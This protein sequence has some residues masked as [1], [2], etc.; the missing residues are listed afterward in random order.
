M[1]DTYL[2]DQS[3]NITYA[4]QV[5]HSNIGLYVYGFTITLYRSQE[6]EI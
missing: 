5:K 2:N 6:S 1:C 4:F 3:M